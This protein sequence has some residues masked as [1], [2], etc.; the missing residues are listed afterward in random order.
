VILNNGLRR[1]QGRLNASHDALAGRLRLALNLMA[2]RVNNKFAPN[3]NGGGFTGGLFT[4]MVIFDPTKPVKNTDGTFYEVGPGAVA[5]R[6]PVALVS[7]LTDLSPEN[8]LLGNFSGTINL[9]EGLTAQTTVGS[10]NTQSNRRFFAPNSSPIGAATNGF[11]RQADRSLQTLNFQQL[12]TY[13]PRISASQEFEVVGGYEYTK[14]DNREFDAATTTFI[15]DVF[16]ADNL[17]A[18]TKVPAGYPYSW[19][20]ESKLAS[21]FGRANYG[22][23]GRYFLTAVMRRDGS[24]RLAPG[25]RWANFPALSASW[26]LSEE[27]FMRSRPFGLSNLALRAGWGKQGNQAVLPYQTLLLL[28]SDPGAL[29]PFGGVIAS[30]L[31]ASQ[32]G[33]PNLKWETATQTNLG[34]D[35]GLRNDRITGAFEIYQK[36]TKDLLLDR[37]VPQPAVV[38]SRIE[39]IGSL[40]NRG[41]EGN[42]DAELWSAGRRSL[43]GGLVF[44]VER[45]QV[46]SLGDTTAACRDEATTKS[47]GAAAAAKCTA[48][49]SGFVNG[50]GQS[51]QWSQ[52]IMRGQ[53]IGTFMAPIFVG[54]V[55]GQQRFKCTA[56]TNSACAA[57]GTTIDP[58]EADREI[59]GTANPD[60]TVGVRNNLT[61]GSIDA[62]WLWRGEFGGKVFNNTALVYLTKSAAAQ[63]RNFLEGAITAPDNVHEA[64]KFSS[65]WIEDR[66][67]VRL[68]NLTLGYALPTGLTRGRATRVYLSA[69][70][71][72]LFTKYTGYDPEVHSTNGGIAVRG[73]DYLTYPP[74]RN[75]TLGARTTF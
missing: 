38:A 6:N 69:D 11:A 56:A 64:A 68:Q 12:L 42:I 5:V 17:V 57:N 35:Y 43:S 22:F 55:N 29:Y 15:T 1:Y 40:R 23:N 60:F 34:I 19:H 62:S 75:F 24:S 13:T 61:W 28:K 3:E 73:L 2:S 59:V 58:T 14:E 26:R 71:L 10:D 18:G 20:S 44:T 45:N 72:A 63:G 53:A 48:I 9:F 50:Q 30:G 39:N 16:G 31:A 65:R 54:V 4:N 51:N 33:N 47:Y 37:P 21:V 7:Q 41:L 52:V 46:T 8:R 36:N 49:T 32:V 25:H 67:F 74:T 66:T 70:N 27:S